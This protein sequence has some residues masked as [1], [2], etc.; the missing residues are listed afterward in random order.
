MGQNV[1]TLR[2]KTLR[3][4]YNMPNFLANYNFTPRRGRLKPLPKKV[5]NY[6][7]Q[8]AWKIAEQYR[9]RPDI[10]VAMINQESGFDPRKISPSDAR[11]IAQIV[12]SCH[13]LANTD[14]PIHAMRYAANHIANLVKQYH[15][16]YNKALSVYN[17]GRPNA[18]KWPWFAKGQTYF[19]VININARAP[20]ELA[21]HEIS[22]SR[23]AG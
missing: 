11:G 14:H 13:P 5:R 8:T 6:F 20:M 12:Q 16:D 17:S 22:V 21:W 19:Y 9:I 18:Y 3:I 7:R 10:F 23:R 2:V 1:N 4:N 15:G